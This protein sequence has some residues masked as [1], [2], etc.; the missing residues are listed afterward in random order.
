V[1]L[2]FVDAALQ[3]SYPSKPIRCRLMRFSS[4]NL[5]PCGFFCES[6][7]QC[8][9]IGAVPSEGG[10]RSYSGRLC[11]TH[12]ASRYTMMTVMAVTMMNCRRCKDLS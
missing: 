12:F 8:R 11:A 7:L 2:L 9:N 10:C 1:F 6:W 4:E 3:V 5:L